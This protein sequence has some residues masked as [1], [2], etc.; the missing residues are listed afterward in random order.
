VDHAINEINQGLPMAADSEF[1]AYLSDLLAPLG[2]ISYR[3]M[4]GKIGVFCGGV[5]L[6]VI[7]EH[8]L[9]L[10]VDQHSPPFF[11]E[12]A[13]SPPLN[14]TK[15]GKSI[16]LAFWRLPERLLDEP[17]EFA[18]WAHAALAAAQRVATQRRKDTTVL[19]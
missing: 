1:T 4:F 11:Q 15:R 9:Y 16:D 6:G 18:Q 13:S 14:Y 10:R 5:M 7:H 19:F 3:R 8:E 17:E 12:A 2:H